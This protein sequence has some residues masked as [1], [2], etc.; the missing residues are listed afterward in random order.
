MVWSSINTGGVILTQHFLLCTLCQ[1][2]Y[3]PRLQYRDMSFYSYFQVNLGMHAENVERYKFNDKVSLKGQTLLVIL[4]TP[5]VRKQHQT[6]LESILNAH[7]D[8]AMKDYTR[9][10]YM[11]INLC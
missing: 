7:K 5:D 8:S 6:S 9:G 11:Y 10:S 1:Y 2:M 3:M 4:Y